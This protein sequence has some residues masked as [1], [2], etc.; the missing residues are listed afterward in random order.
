MGITKDLGLFRSFRLPES[1]GHLPFIML[2][3]PIPILAPV[4][5]IVM[6]INVLK[7]RQMRLRTLNRDGSDR[8][9]KSA[10][11][12]EAERQKV[13]RNRVH[14]LQMNLLFLSNIAYFIATT[15][16]YVYRE[17]PHAW[18]ANF[19]L[20]YFTAVSFGHI[21]PPAPMATAKQHK[22]SV[23]SNL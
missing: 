17:S 5:F 6:M 7:T 4:L 3:L 18:V 9:D 21:L 2:T 13:V 19:V 10:G 8:S 1:T 15:Y 14:L 16:K 20:F 12:R 22:Q 23:Q 11:V